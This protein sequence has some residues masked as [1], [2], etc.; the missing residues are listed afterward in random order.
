[1]TKRRYTPSYTAEFRAR[2]VRLFCAKLRLVDGEGFVEM[3]L[4]NYPNLSPRY[5]SIIPLKNIYVPDIGKP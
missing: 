4:D 2:G 5:R 1:M 3:V